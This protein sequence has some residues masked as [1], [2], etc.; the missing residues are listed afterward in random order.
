MRLGVRL[1]VR[2]RM[3]NATNVITSPLALELSLFL[4]A[5][6]AQAVPQTGD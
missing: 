3:P 6:K 4:H 2:Q 1:C 5:L